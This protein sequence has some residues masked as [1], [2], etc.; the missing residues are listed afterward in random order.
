MQIDYDLFEVLPDHSTKLHATVRGSHH[1]R[2][3]WEILGM[4]TTNECY[5]AAALGHEVLA[6]VNQHF[7]AGV[8][9]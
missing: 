1:A 3:Q 4:Q 8:P 6:R 5:A 2:E 9:R 7:T